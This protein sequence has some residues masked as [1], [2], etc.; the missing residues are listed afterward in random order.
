[1]PRELGQVAMA[2]ANVTPKPEL[3]QL[4]EKFPSSGA[5]KNAAPAYLRDR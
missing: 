1:M 2:H 4:I 5:A 3:A